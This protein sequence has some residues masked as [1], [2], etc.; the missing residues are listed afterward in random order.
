VAQAAQR[1]RHRAQCKGV[2]S[3]ESKE[4]AIDFLL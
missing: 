2:R 1:V 3:S 4:G